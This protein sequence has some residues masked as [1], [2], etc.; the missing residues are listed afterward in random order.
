MSHEIE[1]I[2]LTRQPRDVMR[3]LKVAYRIYD[4]D[5]HWVAPLLADM[6]KVFTDG[7]P[8]FEHAEMRLWLARRDGQDIGRIAGVLDHHHN[9]DR[10]PSEHA[11]FWGFF[12]CVDDPAVARALFDAVA[13]WT[14]QHNVPRLLGPMNPTSNDECGILVEGFDSRPVFM[15]PFNPRY[16]PALAESAGFVKAKDLLAFHI[17]L[18]SIPMDRLTRIGEKVMKRNP[19]L[20]LTRVSRRTLDGDLAKVKEVYNAAW[21]DNWGFVPMTDAE[22]D[23]MAERLKPLF[24]EG[25]VWLAEERGETIAF[26]LAMPDYNVALQPLR[27]RLLSPGLINALPYFLGWKCPKLSRVITLG[28]K[29]KHRG[30]GL[31]TAMLVE[32]LRTGA[33]VGF[34][35]AEASWILEDNT[36]MCRMLEAIHARVYKRY[37]IY[38]KPV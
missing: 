27:G 16:Y 31:E 11:A 22:L 34:T 9:R 20:R 17:D 12:E 15:M 10:A 6:K 2:S 18:A 21:E 37:R 7:N 38:E 1:I 3:F 5:P 35:E 28:V 13:S 32:G 33:R 24:M 4:S 30:R 19:D 29:R 26:L 36:M 23:F 25:L 8:I 14:R